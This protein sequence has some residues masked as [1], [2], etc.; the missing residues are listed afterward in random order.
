MIPLVIRKVLCAKPLSIKK[1]FMSNTP[2][3]SGTFMR[4]SAPLSVRDTLSVSPQAKPFPAL[5][6]SE[7]ATLYTHLN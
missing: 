3:S 6:L 4:D 1:A 2:I 5:P 7:G